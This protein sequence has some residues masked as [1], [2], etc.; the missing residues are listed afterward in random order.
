MLNMR[1]FLTSLFLLFFLSLVTPL[2]AQTHSY[3]TTEFAYKQVNSYGRWTNWTS[4]ED[5][6]ML[7]TINFSTD[8]V[9]IYSPVTQTY[10]ITEFVRDFTD[11]S[12]GKQVEFNF[13]DQ[14]GDRG[15]MRL[16]IERNGNSQI[17]IEFA[18]VMWVYNVVR[19]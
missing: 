8:I 5:S 13:I 7:I 1:R 4:W 19:I 2:L 12:G 17:Y 14:D 18:N 3:R 15:S 11:S 9:K 16:R 10:R 6:D